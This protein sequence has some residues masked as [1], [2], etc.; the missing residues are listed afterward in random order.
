MKEQKDWLLFKC[1]HLDRLF[2]Y[3]WL[4]AVEF[5]KSLKPSDG[6]TQEESPLPEP[7]LEL[8]VKE[9]CNEG[10]VSMSLK[11]LLQE[12][13]NNKDIEDWIQVS[14]DEITLEKFACRTYDCWN[15]QFKKRWIKQHNSLYFSS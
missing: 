4:F 15:E 6:D 1:R 7:H 5:K 10:E 13:L 3:I 8:T 2:H 12:N 11:T 14:Q 9:D